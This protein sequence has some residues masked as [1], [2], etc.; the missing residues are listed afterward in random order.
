MRVWQMLK[1][2]VRTLPRPYHPICGERSR[3]TQLALS[4]PLNKILETGEANEKRSD[5]STNL[6]YYIKIPWHT[7]ADKSFPPAFMRLKSLGW[8]SENLGA[9]NTAA[10]LKQLSKLLFPIQR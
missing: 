2:K 3:I 9:M 10:P 5:P 6:Q 7:S 1:K 4:L 8:S